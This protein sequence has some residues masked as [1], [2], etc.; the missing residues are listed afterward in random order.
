MVETGGGGLSNIPIISDAIDLLTEIFSQA[1]Q[2][3]DLTRATEQ[4]ETQA[5]SN[6][7]NLAGFTYGLFGGILDSIG[8]LIKGLGSL[9]EHIL[10]D[11]I[12]GHIKALLDAI[13][14]QLTDK[15]SWLRKM[16]ATLQTLQKQYNAMMNQTLR[17]YID[18]VQRIRKVLLPFRLLHIGFAQKLDAKLLG[19]EGR[20]GQMWA[21]ILAHQNLVG[22][23]LNDIID[24][25]GLLRP[26]SIL[27][28]FG[29]MVGAI[30]DAIGAF[31]PG[32]LLCLL[33]GGTVGPET[34]TWVA[35]RPQV[36]AYITGQDPQRGQDASTVVQLTR[37]IQSELGTG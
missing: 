18:L 31:A 6:T 35:Y 26:G 4:V 32:S 24:P 37:M 9:L 11:I 16:I 21:A 8:A 1:A 22:Q 27:G 19:F 14:K 23:I 29:I 36:T 30:H 17:K 12:F 28:S 33:E 7:L 2:I 34:M 3:A 13:W 5:W 25:R 10:K 20:L 15:H